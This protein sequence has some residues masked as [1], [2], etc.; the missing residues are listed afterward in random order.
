MKEL[1]KKLTK[2]YVSSGQQERDKKIM[3]SSRNLLL[4]D[5][6]EKEKRKNEGKFGK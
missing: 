3:Q 2:L 6:L 4:E 1:F 5:M